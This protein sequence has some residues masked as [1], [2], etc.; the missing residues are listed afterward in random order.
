VP[1]ARKQRRPESRKRAVTVSM[2]ALRACGYLWRTGHATALSIGSTSP[3]P[4]MAYA[5]L[6]NTKGSLPKQHARR[7]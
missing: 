2:A 3:T 4:S 7:F 5:M 6:P 1:R